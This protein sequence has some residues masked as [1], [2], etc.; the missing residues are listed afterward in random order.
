MEK[1]WNDL[2]AQ[3]SAT[4]QTPNAQTRKACLPFPG[5][6]D[7]IPWLRSFVISEMPPFYDQANLH[8][9]CFT[10]AI[11]KQDSNT[12]W[13]WA[14]KT[15]LG[16]LTWGCGQVAWTARSLHVSPFIS[17]QDLSTTCC[18]LPSDREWW[19][20]PFS[21]HPLTSTQTTHEGHHQCLVQEN[22]DYFPTS[23]HHRKTSSITR[24]RGI[25]GTLS[26]VLFAN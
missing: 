26:F 7:R 11:Q 2:T 15:Y 22:R 3:G 17:A 5:S 18:Q 25:S 12:E 6:R 16:Q 8:P 20:E 21:P 10:Y 19:T 9:C 1:F 4:P 13:V 14:L 23:S 24:D